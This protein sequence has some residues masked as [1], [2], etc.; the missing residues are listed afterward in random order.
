M[1]SVG[2]DGVPLRIVR[3]GRADLFLKGVRVT[4]AAP[5]EFPCAARAAGYLAGGVVGPGIPG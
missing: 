5:Q 3:G 4:L 2:R 1:A